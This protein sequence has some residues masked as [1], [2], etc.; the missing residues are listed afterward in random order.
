MTGEKKFLLGMG[1]ATLAIIIAGVMLLGRGNKKEN[2]DPGFDTA[3]LTQNV[4][5]S[6]GESTLP[7]TIIEFADI[8]CPA[9][10]QA[11]PIIEKMLEENQGNV[12]F[13][14]RHYPLSSHKNAKIA[15]QAAEAA[16]AQ[17]KFF[18]MVHIQYLKQTDW[19]EKTNPREQFRSY[20]QELGLNIDQFNKEMEDLKSS[21]ES[22]FA[23]GNK[24]GVNSTPTFFI[25]GQKYPGV[26]QA[27][28]FKQII[29]SITSAQKEV[30]STP[31]GFNTSETPGQ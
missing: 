19:S 1:I 22:D 14:F 25:N 15:A 10:K 23:L 11:Q 5:H 26:I 27:E 2:V 13:V 28:K 29:D 31:E 30:E 4:K 20:A 3:Q 21:I 6:Q 18:E 8:Q 24:A 9:C 16:G 12:Y 7:V 17:G